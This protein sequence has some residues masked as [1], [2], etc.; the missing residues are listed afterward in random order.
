MMIGK[1]KTSWSHSKSLTNVGI[2][3]YQCEWKITYL[4]LVEQLEDSI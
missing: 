2:L 3:I 1:N 4:L